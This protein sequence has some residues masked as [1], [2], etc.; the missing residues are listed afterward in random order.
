M[1]DLLD[2]NFNKKDVS[3]L[4]YLRGGYMSF[5]F[6]VVN[7]MAITLM[8]LSNLPRPI[9]VYI[10]IGLLVVNYMLLV[11]HYLEWRLEDTVEEKVDDNLLDD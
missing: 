10:P 4:A 7:I 9:G 3:F 5:S 2:D 8:F 6:T 1:S 11:S